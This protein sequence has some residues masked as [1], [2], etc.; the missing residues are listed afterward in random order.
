MNNK[1]LSNLL[2]YKNNTIIEA[3]R[4]INVNSKGMLFVVDAN[5]KLIGTITDGD[6][7]RA[8]LSGHQLSESI[9]EI[10]NT[11]CIFSSSDISLDE[12]K[13]QFIDNKIKLLPVVDKNKTVI[14]YFEIDDLIDYNRL[15]KENSVLIMAGGLGTRLRP[16]TD[17]IPK[18][19]LKVGDKPILQTIIEQFRNYGFKNILISVNYKSDIIENYFRDGSDFGVN[20]KYI[21]ESKRL[22]TAGAIGIASN[23][24]TK[25]FFVINGDILANVNFYNLLQYHVENN[26]KMTIGSRLYETQIPYGVLNVDEACVTSLEEKPII[27]HLVNGG[28]YVLEPEVIKNIPKEKYF[29]ITELI[30]MLINKKERVGSFPITD[31]WM[32]IGKV[33]DYYRANEEIE[34]YF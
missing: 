26:Y 8:I 20:I 12:L 34:K 17:N 4:L 31:Y 22:G 29:D 14:N 18:P 16:F 23:Y 28:I 25:P 32:D 21:K 27:N 6:I 30:D 3:M 10:Y 19:M 11:N 13:K 7:R 33:E 5:K 2:V 1:D 24:L 9:E 15:E